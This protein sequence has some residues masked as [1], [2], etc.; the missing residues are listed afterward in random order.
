MVVNR[1]FRASLFGLNFKKR[2][3]FFNVLRPMHE[4]FYN[5]VQRFPTFLVVRTTNC[6]KCIMCTYVSYYG[7]LKTIVYQKKKKKP[8]KPDYSRIKQFNVIFRSERHTGCRN[9]AHQD[10]K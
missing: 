4:C 3:L 10:S 6:Y 7:L 1:I 2:L 8:I 5:I 9:I